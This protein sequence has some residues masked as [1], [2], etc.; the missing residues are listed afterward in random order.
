M[1]GRERII[2]TIKQKEID[3]LPLIPI[4]MSIAADEIKIPYLEYATKHKYHIT[5]QIAIAEK[6]DFDHVSAISDPATGVFDCGGHVVFEENEPPGLNEENSLLIDKTDL[7]K[8]K[9]PK[10]EMGERMSNRLEVISGLNKEIGKEKLIEGWIE[11]P[12]AESC[13]LRGINRLMIDF[14]DDSDFVGDLLNFVYD[15]EL[16]F[17]EAQIKAGA[18]IIG[19]GDAA[20]SLL[21]PNLYENYILPYHIKFIKRIHEAGAYVRLHICG[22]LNHILPLMGELNA[23]IVDLDSLTSVSLA[24]QYLGNKT[25]LAGNI[26]PVSTVRNGT[27]DQVTKELQQCFKDAGNMSYGVNAGCEIPRGTPVENLIALRDF[28]RQV[29]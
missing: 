2:N 24:R 14:Y 4:T 25:I 20:A 15:M 8:L 22:N 7:I 12:T 18:D 10:P 21:S 6:Y 26:D 29:N 27:P 11:G 17:A 28:A 19:V 13:D 9:A 3:T 16:T 23:D 1:T 5:G